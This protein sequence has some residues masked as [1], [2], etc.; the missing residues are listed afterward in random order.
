MGTKRRVVQYS[1]VDAKREHPFTGDLELASLFALAEARRGR[2]PLTAMA[3]VYY[4]FHIR[5]W[6]G[7]VLLVDQ[8]G[9]NHASIRYRI[10][11]DVDE[12][13]RALDAAS[14]DPV[15]LREALMEKG[16][17]FRGFA[18]RRMIR[19]DGL[20][21]QPGKAGELSEL[22]ENAVDLEPGDGPLVFKPVLKR[23]DV[24]SIVGSISSLRGEI[25][26]DL[27]HL[28]WAKRSIPGAL[29]RSRG[30]LKGEIKAIREGGAEVKARLREAFEEAKGRHRGLLEE[31]L[32]EIR[33]EYRKQVGPLTRERRKV[34]RRLARLRVRL[35]IQEAEEDPEAAEDPLREMKARLEEV[36]GAI[37][38]LRTWR[39]GEVEDARG[40]YKADL[41][42]EEDKIKGEE[43]RVRREVQAKEA[44]ISELEK[45]AK[46]VAAR[47][48][49]LMRSKRGKLSSLSRLRFDVE[50][51]TMDLSV[52]FYIF[53]YGRKRFDFYPPVVASSP[54]GFLSRFRRMLADNLQSKM[55]QLIRPRAG[56]LERYLGK[57]VRALGR[58]KAHAVEYRQAGDGLNLLRSREAVDKIMTGLVKIRQE[59]WISDGEYIRLQEALVENLGLI[60]RP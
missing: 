22:L 21:V 1:T 8:L 34:K 54:R 6:E 12:F 46:G 4:P 29:D 5:R 11:P 7:G 31:R 42:L 44:E 60:S 3:R 19:I 48:D 25:E 10:I 13:K 58:G 35:G 39:D 43:E 45:L 37:R 17:L 23:G 38:T 30:A 50:A 28:E 41:K 59:G 53:H 51:E 20:I 57:A 40:R 18:G 49:R 26:G 27:R 32:S 56:F 47:I 9:L 15:A 14:N 2:D 52:P 16:A 33:A 24:E 55:T 36:E